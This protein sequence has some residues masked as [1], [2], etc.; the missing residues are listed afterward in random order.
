MK[1]SAFL[2]FTIC[3]LAVAQEIAPDAVVARIDGKPITAEQL[4]KIIQ[5]NPPEAQKGFLANPQAFLEQYALVRNL[6]AEAEKEKLDQQSPTRE[7][8]E[9]FRTQTLAQA[10]F[11][12]MANSI[13][14]QADDQKKFYET[15][16]DRYT[17]AKVKVL[18]VAFRAAGGTDTGAKGKSLTEPEAK[19]KAEKLLGEI[20]LGADFVKLVKE[21]SDDRQSA[22]RDGDFGQPVQKSAQFPE[23]IRAA[24]FSL[25]QGQVSDPVRVSNGFYLFRLEELSVRPFEEV[26][27]D[28]FLEIRQARFSEWMN[29]TRSAIQVKIENPDYFKKAAS[30]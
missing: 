20:R 24:I 28:I 19:A 15:N 13:P 21:N 23:N 12:A 10:K 29:K 6:A 7:R 1:F 2:L 18:F 8:L 4:T 11:D 16:K 5:V 30:K 27:D 3:S 9:L 26:R 25:K 22:E 17:Q 14:V